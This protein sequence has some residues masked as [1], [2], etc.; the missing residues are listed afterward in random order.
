MRSR[1]RRELDRD[2]E[3]I[4]GDEAARATGGP[5][6]TAR[7]GFRQGCLSDLANPKIG[8]FFTSL[9][10][11]FVT[12]GHS[13]LLPF[14]ILGLCAMAGLALG[15]RTDSER[16]RLWGAM[17]VGLYAMLVIVCFWYFYPIWTYV[18]IP[19]SSWNDRIWFPGWF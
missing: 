18:K 2:N 1:R 10:P 17:S 19:Y 15:Q 16:R 4:A 14:L 8:I 6:M 13:V 3:P 11:Q 5:V 7:G 12:A 9:L